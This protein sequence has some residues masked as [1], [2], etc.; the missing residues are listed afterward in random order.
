MGR[1]RETINT[2]YSVNSLTPCEEMHGS[3]NKR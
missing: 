3:K 2:S 1:K